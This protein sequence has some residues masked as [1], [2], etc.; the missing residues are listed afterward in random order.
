MRKLLVHIGCA[1]GGSSAIQKGLRINREALASK[2]ISVPGHDLQP[3]SHVS[4]AHGVFFETFVGDGRATDIPDLGDLLDAQ[5]DEVDASAVVLSAE[6]LSNPMGFERV[7]ETLANRFDISIVFYARRQDDYLASAWQQ[8]HVKRGD[9]LLLWMI[10]SIRFLVGDWNQ[11]L[12]PWS[13]SFG[14]EHIVARVYDRERLVEQDVFLDFLDVLG[15]G[16]EGFES[17]GETNPSL[18]PMLS[19]LVEGRPYLFE[20]PHDQS[21]Y[22]S[23]SELASDLVTKRRDEPGIFSPAEADAIMVAY[24]QSNERFRRRY[25]PNI[26]PPLFPPRPRQ[27]TTAEVDHDAFERELLQLQ[28]FNLHK[29]LDELRESLKQLDGSLPEPEDGSD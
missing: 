23:V 8:W 19:R 17:P 5:A 9:S 26:K 11:T 12:E 6:N 1:K 18:S 20:G 28:I 2:G 21:F 3:G 24:R 13:A 14:D 10:S 25:L 4:G 7:F 22:R 16:A 29:E 27:D 15:V